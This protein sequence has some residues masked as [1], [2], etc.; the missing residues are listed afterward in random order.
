MVPAAGLQVGLDQVESLAPFD[1]IRQSDV[2][3]L[4]P[5]VSH[6]P[7]GVG[8]DPLEK[9]VVSDRIGDQHGESLSVVGEH[10]SHQYSDLDTTHSH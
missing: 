6:D 2:D 9:V 8:F 3:D 5:R 10:M 4:V 7:G 1:G